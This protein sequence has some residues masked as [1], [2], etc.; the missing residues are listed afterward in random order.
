MEFLNEKITEMFSEAV[1]VSGAV[2]AAMV[3]PN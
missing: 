3:S 2:L 1:K